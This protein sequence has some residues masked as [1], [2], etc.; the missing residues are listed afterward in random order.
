MRQS[1]LIA[2]VGVV[3]VGLGILV[4]GEVRAEP[5]LQMVLDNLYDLN[6]LTQVSSDLDTWW[7]NPDGTSS[8]VARF[9][10]YTNDFGFFK[11]GGGAFT[12][13]FTISGTSYNPGTTNNI[14]Q[15]IDQSVTGSL[16]TFALDPPQGGPPG[17]YS[18]DP[19]A[20]YGR[21]HLHTWKITGSVDYGQMIGAPTVGNYVLA[22]EDKF[23]NSDWD[24]QDAVIEVHGF[25]PIP[26]PTTW[27]GLLSMGAMGLVGFTWRRRKKA[28]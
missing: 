9:A 6:N 25:H 5:T 15:P 13:I 3:I 11:D 12:P 17:E 28:A 27:V 7:V 2:C 26:A 18:S 4:T 10:G 20:N 8:A 23:P 19:S 21:D 22:W 16:F 1:R 14:A 24:Y